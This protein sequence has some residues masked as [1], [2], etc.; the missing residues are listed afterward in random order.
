MPDK[1][2]L[3]CLIGKTVASIPPQGVWESRRVIVFTDG[4]S[5]TF[6]ASHSDPYAVGNARLGVCVKDVS[7]Q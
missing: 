7:E 2:D 5:I 1:E 6:T 4:S 3:T